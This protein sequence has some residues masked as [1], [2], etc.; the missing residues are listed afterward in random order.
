MPPSGA[1][2]HDGAP[3]NSL[4][5]HAPMTASTLP[6]RNPRTGQTDYEMPV[7]SAEQVAAVA[8]ALRLAQAAWQDGG[9]DAR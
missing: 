9:A 6:T 5:Q 2:S 8:G 4:K 3:L 1:P 7:H